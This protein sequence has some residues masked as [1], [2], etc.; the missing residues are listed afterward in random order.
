VTAIVCKNIRLLAMI[1]IIATLVAYGTIAGQ[2]RPY[3]AWQEYL[4]GPETSHYS[5][6]T[7]INRF[8]VK[9]LQIAWRYNTD[10]AVAYDFNPLIVGKVMYVLAKNYSIVAL[11]ATTGK[12][13]WTY[14]DP[15]MPA[16]G[17]LHGIS[18]WE[19]K[20]GKQQRLLF[21]VGYYLEEID[22]RTGTLISSFGDQGKLDLR[23]GLGRDPNS[24][25][26]IASSSPGAIYED[27]IIE[28]S[29]T[30]EDYGS[31]PGDIRAYNV[32]SGKLAWTFHMV[33]H[34]GEVGYNTW[35]K[36]AW[37]YSGGA[38]AW[39]G[40]A[41]DTKRGMV[42]IPTA[43]PKNEF[44]GGDRIGD[45]LFS[46]C[47]VALDAHT[48]K[49]IWY[50][51]MVHHDIWDYDNTA[52]PQLVTV[53]HDGKKMDV[54]AEA[55]KTGFL[56]VFDR[57]TGKPL[58]PIEE[59]PVPDSHLPG[60]VA[61]AT[62]PFPTAPPPFARQS[63]TADDVDPYILSPAEQAAWKNRIEKAVNMGLFTPPEETETVEMPGNRG[64]A[65]VEMSASDP[66][67]G[68][69]YVLSMDL[70]GMLRMSR[71][72][73]PSL[74]ALPNNLPAAQEGRAV[75]E[76]FCQRCHGPDRQGAPP[77]I[78]SLVS[79]PAQLGPNVIS[80]VVQNG[81]GNMPAFSDLTGALLD[82]LINYLA[83]PEEAS[84]PVALL[85]DEDSKAGSPYPSTAKNAP[86][87]FYY[88]P[89]GLVPEPIKP[90]WS[91]ITAFDLSKGT[92]LWQIPFG[93]APQ[94]PDV[95]NSSIM[96]PRNGVVVTGGGLI[97]AAT[98]D[99]G[100]L[101][102]YDQETG[103]VLWST[104]LPAASEGVP[105]VYEAGGREYL[106]LPV[107]TVKGTNLPR[108]R[109]AIPQPLTHPVERSYIAL[110]LPPGS[111]SEK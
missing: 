109:S 72:Q 35:P 68:L 100:K 67:H 92:I 96:E 27:L 39:G 36:N 88:T 69:V 20:D 46:D 87:T 8:N 65:N 37:T 66:E 15:A 93:K 2:S 89:Y 97:F 1:V 101:R 24:I 70:P 74:F 55:G 50:Y 111:G 11:D 103:D 86:N 106:V 54:V 34:P 53:N 40:L 25:K 98:L 7:Q 18:F 94:A 29:S 52:S 17:E 26:R 64:G 71:Q 61:A 85:R 41:V 22:A 90:P 28:G 43:A 73:P 14:R 102:A 91:T 12:E 13:L 47:L 57:V 4:G 99:E 77:S 42:F 3:T 80:S 82:D 107:C 58:W 81:F 75:Y 62:Q 49:L 38:D 104:D 56:Y 105:A 16:R 5:A 45:N 23:V 31:P 108:D 60:E 95:P 19:S 78:P 83:H 79:A 44:Y 6:L 48:G 33:P 10:D 51:Q 30:G 59:R 76:E 63:F 84:A 9:Q 110:A 21:P 32:L